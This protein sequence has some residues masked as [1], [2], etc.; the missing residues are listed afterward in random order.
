[1]FTFANR[2]KTDALSGHS[3]P[4]QRTEVLTSGSNTETSQPANARFE[5][6]PREGR[7]KMK[8]L[9]YCLFLLSLLL[10]AYGDSVVCQQ[11]Y[12]AKEG[13]CVT[14]RP[15]HGACPKDSKYDLNW[16]LCVYE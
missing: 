9:W 3:K 7:P 12:T 5:N 15:V 6:T 10:G 16:N 13:K 2:I 4:P 1:M 11:G 8:L 14:Q